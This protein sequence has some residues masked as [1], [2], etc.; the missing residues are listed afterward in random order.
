MEIIL[1]M[2]ALVLIGFIAICWVQADV[3][4]DLRKKNEAA[5][6]EIIRLQQRN[7]CLEAESKAF[8]HREEKPV[9]EEIKCICAYTKE[10][11][12]CLECSSRDECMFDC[13][14]DAKKCNRKGR[15]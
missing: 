14:E 12:C 11:A 5:N 15:R 1:I 10:A 2:L 9:L 13:G 3:N 8:K 7:Y 4:K 6:K